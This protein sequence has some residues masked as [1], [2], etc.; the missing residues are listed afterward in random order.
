MGHAADAHLQDL[1]RVTKEFV[2][3]KDAFSHIVGPTGE[4]HLPAKVNA[5]S[6]QVRPWI[7]A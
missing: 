4:D 3:V 1:P 7:C 5:I 6:N 2:Q